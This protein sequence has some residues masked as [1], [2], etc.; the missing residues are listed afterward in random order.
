MAYTASRVADVW[1]TLLLPLCPQE[2]E[3]LAAKERLEAQRA[4]VEQQQQREVLLQERYKALLDERSD[5]L[6]AQQQGQQQ[7]VAVQ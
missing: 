1:L 6:A 7:Q 4:L 5:L 3:V 2:R